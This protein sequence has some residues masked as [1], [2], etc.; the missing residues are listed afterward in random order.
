[1]RIESVVALAALGAARLVL[2]TDFEAHCRDIASQL[3]VANSTVWFS[4]Y[5]PGGTNLTFPD[6]NVTCARPAQVIPKD[7]CRVAL[8]VATSNRSGI[9]MET[10]LPRDW[11]GRLLS[12]GN[13]GLG[14]CIQYEDMAYTVGLGFATIGANNGHNGTSGG[15]F[16][17]N[18]DVVQDFAWRSVYTGVVVGKQISN[19]FYGAPHTKSYYLGCSTGGRQGLKMVQDFPDAFDGVVAG[20]PANA[21][22]NLTSWSGHFYTLTGPVNASTFIPAS[23]WPVIHQD[24]LD[25]CDNID[26]YADGILEDPDLCQYRPESLICGPGNTT[27]CLTGEQASTLRQIFSPLYGLDGSLVY[28]RLQPGAER[29]AGQAILNGRPFPYTADWFRYAVYNDPSWD[30]ATLDAAD[31]AYATRLNP[32]GIETWKGDLSAFRDRGGKLLTYHGLQDGIITSDNSARYYNYVSRTMNLPSSALDSFYRYFRIS[33]MEHCSGGPG[34]W[35]IGQSRGNASL[36][37][38]ANI[39][40]AMVRWVENTTAPES[41][42]GTKFVNDTRSLGVAFQRAHCKYPTR[43]VYSGD[44]DPTEPESWDCV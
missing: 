42:L 22:N 18:A 26:G 41:I 19:A 44:G 27:N 35:Q 17:N 33:G 14:G 21:F 3:D 36:S 23:M 25:Q 38:D 1:M 20:A 10:W 43:N 34:A 30:P 11:T 31:Y 15:A 16:Y 5:V 6:N 12:T 8:Y 2:A 29:V 4:Q 9:S 40:M 7:I 32:G 13:G 39:L 24:I 28:P 37:P